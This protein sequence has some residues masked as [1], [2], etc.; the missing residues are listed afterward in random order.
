MKSRSVVLLL[1]AAILL[2]A[3]LI[4][5]PSLHNKFVF[6]DLDQT[7]YNSAVVSDSMGDSLLSYR[8][9]RTLSYWVDYHL[10]GGTPEAFRG[11]N[12]FYHLLTLMIFMLFMRKFTGSHSATLV[13]SALFALHPIHSD[14][15][16][17]ISG[18]RDI[19]TALF[20]LVS[21]YALIRGYDT[22][23][24][25]KYRWYALA[26]VAFLFSYFSKETGIT[27]PIIWL[28][29][30]WYKKGSAIFKTRWFNAISLVFTMLIAIF[31]LY[32]VQQGASSLIS[33]QSVKFHGDSIA[34]HYL[35]ALTL[36]LYYLKQVIFPLHLIVDNINYP[37]VTQLNVR[38]LFSIVGIVGYLGIV[39]LLT[40]KSVVKEIT[41]QS[42]YRQIAFFLFFFVI[43][44]LPM[45]QIIPLHE[46]VAEHYLYLSSIAFCAI[47]GII[48][49]KA[50]KEVK[51]GDKKQYAMIFVFVF[52]ALFFMR[53]SF[54]RNFEMENWFTILHQE[55]Q[56]GELSYRGYYTLASEYMALGF[57]AEAKEFLDKS[58][59]TKIYDA[60]YLNVRLQWF[61]RQGKI[62]DGLSFYEKNKK[63]KTLSNMTHIDAATA[64]Y[65]LGDCKQV[66]RI[67]NTVVP[68]NERQKK[69]IRFLQGC[70]EDVALPNFEKCTEEGV[71]KVDC[72]LNQAKNAGGLM[73]SYLLLRR[74]VDM[75]DSRIT[76]STIMLLSKLG[77]MKVGAIPLYH[78]I[79]NEES[80]EKA[81]IELKRQLATMLM[82][83]DVPQSIVLY[84]E[85]NDTLQRNFGVVDRNIVNLI[86]FLENYQH[87]ILVEEQYTEIKM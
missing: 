13:A 47:A 42:P 35:T 60:N 79:L 41:V 31:A 56:N 22:G 34:I 17:Y 70:N 53:R 67:A 83:I 6:D 9:V 75:H 4:R 49:A 48:V 66:L 54:S 39:Y 43:T 14:A 20:Y 27:L 44:L 87:T 2:I 61:L 63:T 81:R 85:I 46:I 57:P 11:M 36:P 78:R 19:L 37:L 25:K 58:K 80:D 59:K 24:K 18:R 26:F 74:H 32:T 50:L 55:Q 45:L 62:F 73:N 28:L 10:F 51:D 38:L 1:Y 71:G 5:M 52:F 84:K 69:E 64:Y 72:I 16:I 8:P 65:I 15:V 7:I 33:F 40:R 23:E 86:A 76:N 21:L 30:L 77:K 29:Y 82:K 3:F 68:N 12:I